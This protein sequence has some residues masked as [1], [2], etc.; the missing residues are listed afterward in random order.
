MYAKQTQ[1]D[2]AVPERRDE[3]DEEETEIP[4]EPVRQ[5]TNAKNLN[6]DDTIQDKPVS[7]PCTSAFYSYTEYCQ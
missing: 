7:L 5:D 3:E 6:K 4:A 1:T 2:I